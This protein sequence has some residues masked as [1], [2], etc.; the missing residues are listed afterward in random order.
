[1]ENWFRKPIKSKLVNTL[2]RF[3]GF[4]ISYYKDLYFTPHIKHETKIQIRKYLNR[5]LS[6]CTQLFECSIK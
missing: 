5:I 1:M 6:N 4:G 2:V 3:M